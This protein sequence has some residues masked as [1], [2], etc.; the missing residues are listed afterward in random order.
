MAIFF[1]LLCAVV[2]GSADFCGGLATRRTALIAVVT[3]SQCS[4]L[5][6]LLAVVPFFGGAPAASDWWWGAASGIAGGLAIALLYRG[7]AIGT[8]GI[9]SPITA[10]LAALVPVAFGTPVRGERPSA[11]TFVGIAAAVV[12]VA[13]VS[14]SP[15]DGPRPERRAAFP[16]GLLEAFGAG[17]LFG[18]FFIG[19]AQTHTA[20]GMLP[21]L[22]ARFAASAMLLAGALA[23]GKARD[24]RVSPAAL[25]L[26]ILCG[27]LDGGANI[28]YVLAAHG[29]MLSVVAVLSSLY[30][31][32]TVALAAIVL[33]E[34]L[35]LVQQIGVGVAVA[36]V[37]AISVSH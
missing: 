32:A 19:L 28:F 17:L 13:C 22:A 10:V 2:Y 5:V 35:T 3:L 27:V 36:G 34:R 20:A 4:G 24:L 14:A 15:G 1:S 9:V 26:I 29:G 25:P 21:L 18:A 11:L 30:P 7:L 8:M 23:L 12:A 16:P 31:A 6:L 37:C 33:G